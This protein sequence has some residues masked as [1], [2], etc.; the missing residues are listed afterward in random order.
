MSTPGR[1]KGEYRRAHPESIPMSHFDDETRVTPLGL[2]PNGANTAATF[3]GHV[4]AAWNIGANPN[5]GY[6]LALG[7]QALRQV[8]PTQPDPLSLTVHYLRPGLAGQPC[9]IDTQWL[10][11]GR[12][13]GTLR[14]TLVQDGSARLELL[15]AM[16]DLGAPE[17]AAPPL[18]SRPMPDIPPPEACPGRS[19]PAQGVALPILQRLD[20]RLHPDEA[21]PGAAG[22]AQV[23]GWIRLADG[24]APD[25]LACVLMADAFP[26]SVFGLL[27]QVGWVPTIELTVHLRRRPA[28]GWLLGQFWSHDLSDGRM[29][30]DGALWDASGQLVL[31]SRQLALV[32]QA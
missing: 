15:A 19:A 2:V 30:E 29:V 27:G 18:L 22:K 23:S 11:S 1:R 32:R 14:A 16:G 8:T 21:V 3:A 13:L 6:L 7:A 10:R 20:I 28:P 31:Q 24:R 4:H 12:T 26:P 5:G 17:S 9:R 25:A